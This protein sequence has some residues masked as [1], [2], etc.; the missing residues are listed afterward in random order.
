VSISIP[1]RRA[2]RRALALLAAG[3][4][5]AGMLAALP[6]A[7]AA[8]GGGGL[9]RVPAPTAGMQAGRYVVLLKSPSATQYDGSDPRYAATRVLPGES[10]A[11]RSRQVQ[12]YSRHLVD[13]HATLARSVGATPLTHFTVGSNGFVA[14]LTG[15]Q[16]LDLSSS[17][18]VLLVSKDVARRA[19]TWNTPEF[20]GLS[21]SKGVWQR[22]A[23]GRENAG[24]GVVVGILD[25]GIWPES[26]SFS[27]SSL[28]KRPKTRWNIRRVGDNVRMDKADGGVFLGRCQLSARIAGRTVA[29]KR[30]KASDCNTKIIGARYYPDAFLDSIAPRDRSED[31][32]LSTRDGDGHGS[33]TASTSAGNTV[34]NV[35][36]EDVRFGTASGMAPAARLAAYKV[37]FS[38]NDEE[39]GDCFT[40]SILEAIDDA[41]AD[42]VDVI[43]MSISGVAETVVDPVEIAFEGA[44]EAGIFV[45]TS[46]GNSGP[47]V[48]TVAHN[49]PWLTTVAAATHFRFENTVVL[50]NGKRIRGASISQQTLPPRTRLISSTRA[51]APGADADAAALCF[52]GGSLD[53]DKVDGK[54]VVCERGVNDRVE[55]SKAVKRAGGVGMILANVTPGSLD[56]D[57]HSVPTIHISDKD[58]PKVLRYL[59]RQG[60][61]ATAAFRQGDTTG[62]K[63]T[64]VPEMA[65]FSSRG[66]G[67]ASDSDLLKPDI[68]GPGVSILAAVAP[69]ANEDRDY[70]L[71]SGTSM[72]SPHIA[73]IAAF[74]MGERTGWTPMQ[75]KSAMMTTAKSVRGTNGGKVRDPFQQ[76]AGHVQ[77]R[78]AFDPGL[79]VT[80]GTRDWRGFLAGQGLPNGAQPIAAKDFNGPSLA[81]GQ[82]TSS[83]KFTRE[84]LADRA[85]TWKV[86]VKVPGFKAK[87]KKRIHARGQ[88]DRK[89]LTVRFTRTDAPLG[90]W[91][92]GFVTLSGP[93]RLRMPV[94]LRPVS[95]RAPAEVSGVGVT[96]QTTVPITAGFTGNLDVGVTGLAKA[97]TF[98]GTSSNITVAATDSQFFCVQ[99]A[100]GSKAARFSLDAANNAAD[101]DMFVYS[102]ADAACEQLNDVA[103]QSATGAADEQVTLLDPEPGFYLVEVDP[104]TAAPGEPTLTWRLDFYDV[105]S[106][107]QAGAF[108]AV[109][110]P[111]PV[112]NNQSTSFAAA[113]TGL[114][115]N[116]R[117]LGVLEYAGALSPTFVSVDTAS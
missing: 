114:E 52:I 40:S 108:R 25:S 5:A 32:S 10:F 53:P 96:G 105:N 29:A 79:F 20:L 11:G 49:S 8:D 19:D 103:G 51:A 82:V 85:G 88:G 70:D 113:W 36:T 55:K 101:M 116:A 44:A 42:G 7:D 43:N 41:V 97:Q 69:P 75:V 117:Y 13:E 84:L 92:T 60:G 67:L 12:A 87:A 3:A 77:V 16:A 59:N 64:P 9:D 47:E 115:A 33:H 68:T 109:P 14:D 65:A 23:G 30:W 45:T 63:P 6:T 21:G 76:G 28:T 18:D 56:A 66:P 61:R 34:R 74:M 48:S 81:Q 35:R 99:V 26:R 104:F 98:N 80:S 95:V 22:Q 83:T 54:I 58:T 71:Y 106:A 57:F 50:G 102:A 78:Q 91:A 86:K 17:R 27:G 46:A 4:V 31:E 38:D 1:A 37:C 73:G 39:S 72:A 62:K 89:R 100:G 94:A 93:T 2:P 90:R 24:D 112:S 107:N 111:V 110:D 15:Q